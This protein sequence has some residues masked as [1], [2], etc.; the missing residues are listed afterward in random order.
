MPLFARLAPSLVALIE[1]A[2]VLATVAI[3]FLGSADSPGIRRLEIKFARLARRKTLS[4]VIVT[5]STLLLR[6]ALIPVL[7]VPTPRWEDEFSYLL[8]ADTFAHG[9]L[10]NPTHPMWQHFETLHEI[11]QPTYMSMYPPAQGL[12]LAA[13]QKLGNPWIGQLIITAL[14][15]GAICWMLQSWVPPGWALLG[16]MLAMLRLG[17]L[18]YW[19]NGYWSATIVALGGAMV[20]GALPRIK[21]HAGTGAAIVMALGLAILANSRPYEGFVLSLPVF[22]AMLVWLI[23]KRPTP[24]LRVVF[25]IFMILA[26]TAIATGYYYHRVTGSAFRMTYVVNRA[27]YAIAPYFFWQ[28]PNPEP[29]YRHPAMREFYHWEL[30]LYQANLTPLGFMRRTADKLSLWW[31]FYLGPLLTIP[32]FAFPYVLRDRRMRFP[33]IVLAIFVLGLALEVFN[34]PHYFAPATSLLYLVL[35][36]CMRHLRL[37]QW[38]QKPVG[39]ALVRSIPMLALAMVILRVGAAALHAPIEPAWPRGNLERAHIGKCLAA[40][41]GKSLV[42]VSQ[43]PILVDKE[44]VYNDADIDASNVVWARDMGEPSNTELAEYFRGR[45]IWMLSFKDAFEDFP[46]LTPYG[47]TVPLTCP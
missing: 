16:G 23:K 47:G 35:I 33:L 36:Q 3:V 9:R 19:M 2:F 11:Q 8:A 13:G 43:H 38:K 29:D 31:S 24:W 17:L 28:K 22:A 45:H 10:T 4:V 41:P 5:L 26:T 40:R 44:W 20:L 12:A 15:C 39:L 30:G 27:Q 14:M 34:F 37:W 42:I 25:P 18:S 21:R 1:L 7:G 46:V 32:L 6:A